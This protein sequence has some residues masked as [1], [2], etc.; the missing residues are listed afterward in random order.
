MTV[1]TKRVGV[2]FPPRAVYQ[3]ACVADLESKAVLSFHSHEAENS[4]FDTRWRTSSQDMSFA[5][6]KLR[7]K[8]K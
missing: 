8:L 5:G 1:V 6:V 3:R 7:G 4:L 2:S